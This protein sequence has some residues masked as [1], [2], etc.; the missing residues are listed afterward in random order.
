MSYRLSDNPT[1]KYTKG[2]LENTIKQNYVCHPQLFLSEPILK[3]TLCFLLEP[4]WVFSRQQMTGPGVS[5]TLSPGLVNLRDEVN[6]ITSLGKFCPNL[7]NFLCQISWKCSISWLHNNWLCIHQLMDIFLML[8]N[9]YLS[10][11]REWTSKSLPLIV[12]KYL[13][14]NQLDKVELHKI[15]DPRIWVS[16]ISFQ[17]FILGR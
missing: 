9:L 8:K 15:S 10:N 11:A 7:K 16:I 17:S 2:K 6:N 12:I 3:I 13:L 14:S 1:P 4:S 5:G